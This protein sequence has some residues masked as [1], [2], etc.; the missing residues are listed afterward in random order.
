MSDARASSRAGRAASVDIPPLQGG[1]RRAKRAGRGSG[2]TVLP[3]KPTRPP[4]FAARSQAGQPP[5]LQGDVPGSRLALRSARRQQLRRATPSISP[6]F[7]RSNRSPLQ[8]TSAP[9]SLPAFRRN[10]AVRRF[11]AHGPLDPTIRDFVGLSENAWDFNTPGLDPGL[12]ALEMTRGAS[13]ADCPSRRPQSW[14]RGL[15]ASRCCRGE[16][17]R[18]SGTRS[19]DGTK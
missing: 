4:A 15:Q 6:S 12:W 17:V 19:E 13:P 8:A 3:T 16:C 5:A 7:R 10:C 18:K 14:R 9:S 11:V 2:R 1:G